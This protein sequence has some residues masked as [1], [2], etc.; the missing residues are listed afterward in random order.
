MYSI[1]RYREL[2]PVPE[3]LRS[4]ISLGEG[5]TPLIRLSYIEELTDTARVYVKFEGCNP[6]GSFKDRGMSL[7]VTLA[8]GI[9]CKYYIVASTGNTAASASAY[10]ANAGGRCIILIPHG[11]TALGKLAQA[12]LHG[13]FVIEVKG[14][15][16]D[17]LA[18][19]FTL[20]DHMNLYPLNS[21]NPW[22][23]EGQKTIA[24][25]IAEEL[26]DSVDW[27][28]VPVGNAGNIYAIGKGFLELYL[29]G[30][31]NKLP[32]IA[33]IQASGANPLVRMWS[34]G[35]DKPEFIDEPCT[36]ASAVKIGRP[37]N[38]MK[39]V[40]I[41]RM[42]DGLFIDV[43]DDEILYAQKILARC[44]VGVEPAG[45]VSIAGLFKLRKLDVISRSENV[46]C[47][48]TGHALKD[49]E[50]ILSRYSS[51]RIIA[52]LDDVESIIYEVLRG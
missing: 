31:I 22:R 11:Y 45:A 40:K 37:V 5:C 8:R 30:L 4:V 2:L 12:L 23:L 24:F 15:F 33:G 21:I 26:G 13:A 52:E 14:L 16:D 49:P 51:N 6:T 48:A 42:L 44:G 36:I 50:I 10:V 34:K 32:R 43:S 18:K 9:G 39:A 3:D 38:W 27:I 25:E 35:L 41:V 47:I 29:I 28:I 1:W 20:L 17:A 46:V 7:A 19:I